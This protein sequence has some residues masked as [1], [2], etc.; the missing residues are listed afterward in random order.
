MRV[1]E[2]LHKF[3]FWL[4]AI[5]VGCACSLLCDSELGTRVPGGVDVWPFIL[6][7]QRNSQ[8]AKGSSIVT[9]HI[10]AAYGLNDQLWS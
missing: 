4:E 10:Y 7:G 8:A 3:K 9:I 1:C 5:E 2:C 6:A